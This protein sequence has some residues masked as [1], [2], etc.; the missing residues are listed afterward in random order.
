LRLSPSAMKVLAF[1]IGHLSR[2]LIDHQALYNADLIAAGTADSR[3]LNTITG[4]EIVS[5]FR[6]RLLR[7]VN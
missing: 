7:I 3:T 2:Y 4:D 6:I 5:H 1:G